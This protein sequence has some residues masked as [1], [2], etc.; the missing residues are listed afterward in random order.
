MIDG[1]SVPHPLQL[2]IAFGVRHHFQA[3]VSLAQSAFKLCM[4]EHF[5]NG[6]GNYC[7]PRV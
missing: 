2:A 4:I 7:Q 6:I 5:R 3:G 1:D